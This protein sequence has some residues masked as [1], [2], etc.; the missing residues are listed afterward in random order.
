MEEVA[1]GGEV[2]KTNEVQAAEV[3]AGLESAKGGSEAEAS[4]VS[5]EV[6]SEVATN[7]TS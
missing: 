3:I 4:G 5:E 2:L 1:A 6:V 7:P